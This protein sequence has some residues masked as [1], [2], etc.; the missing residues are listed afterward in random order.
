ML[1]LVSQH[2][3]ATRDWLDKKLVA[4]Q[5]R[6]GKGDVFARITSDQGG[7]SN[8]EKER[9]AR[10]TNEWASY[11]ESMLEA[12]DQERRAL[13]TRKQIEMKFDAMRSMNAA[14]RANMNSGSLTT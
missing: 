13:W 6:E 9:Q 7:G 4:E 12:E 10:L 2:A 8:A 3:D 11:R 14:N 5:L 1:K